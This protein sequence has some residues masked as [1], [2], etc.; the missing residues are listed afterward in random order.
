MALAWDFPTEWTRCNTRNSDYFLFF[1]SV[2]WFSLLPDFLSN[3]EA[4]S[5][6]P[7]CLEFW[8]PPG[9][10]DRGPTFL[11]EEGKLPKAVFGGIPSQSSRN[12]LILLTRSRLG[13][14]WNKGLLLP[15][16]FR[17]LGRVFRV[18]SPG[19]WI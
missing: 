1:W 5:Q 9:K 16:D 2:H 14:G 10:G 8:N 17:A 18:S 12:D 11:L 19:F 15:L 6:L 13:A 3:A 7:A 4:R